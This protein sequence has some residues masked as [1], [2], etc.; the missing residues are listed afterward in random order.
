MP[1]GSKV[2]PPRLLCPVT[3]L[4]DSQVIDRCPLAIFF[5]FFFFFFYFMS[6]EATV[7]MAFI[8]RAIFNR[9]VNFLFIL[10]INKMCVHVQ[11]FGKEI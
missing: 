3:V 6:G 7:N 1:L 5:F 8:S 11:P 10:C 2:A 4:V 9:N